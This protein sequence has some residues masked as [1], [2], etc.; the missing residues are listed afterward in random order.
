MLK[1]FSLS[2]CLLGIWYSVQAQEN[3]LEH[4]N[5]TFIRGGDTL[6]LSDIGGINTPIYNNIDLNN[7]GIEDLVIFDRSSN[8]ILPLLYIGE[9]Q[10]IA[11]KFAPEYTIGFPNNISEFLLSYDYNGDNIKDIIYNSTETYS[12]AIAKGNYI[13]NKIHFEIVTEEIMV[14]F[15]N[16]TYP[17]SGLRTDLPT[18]G[19][20]DNDGDMDILMFTNSSTYFDYIMWYKNMAIERGLSLDSLVFEEGSDCFAHMGETGIDNTF[21][22]S[23]DTSICPNNPYWRNPRHIGSTITAIDHNKD[24]VLDLV[25]GDIEYPHL[26]LVSLR[27]IG[28]T[29]IAYAQD[30]NYPSNDTIVH[31]LD[32]P[33]AYYVDINNDGKLDL[34]AANFYNNSGLLDSTSWLYLNHAPDANSAMDMR[35]ENKAFLYDQMLDLGKGAYPT[36]VDLNADGLM[37]LVIGNARKGYTI[38][39]EFGS[40]YAFMNVGTDTLPIFELIN[41]D[42]AQLS[43][44]QQSKLI[45]DFGDLNGDGAIDMV[46]GTEMGYIYI[47]LNQ[48]APDQMPIYT[49]AENTVLE[50]FHTDAG[51]LFGNSAPSLYDFDNDGDLDIVSGGNEG[52]LFYFENTGNANQYAFDTIPTNNRFGNVYVQHQDPYNVQIVPRVITSDT[53]TKM[54]LAY[55]SSDIL[56]VS[57]IDE[58]LLGSFDVNHSDLYSKFSKEEW[59]EQSLDLADLN[60]DSILDLVIG[61]QRGGVNFFFSRAEISDTTI[62]LTETILPLQKINI[63]PNPAKDHIFIDF[64]GK[65]DDNPLLFIYNL[66]GQLVQT[67]ALVGKESKQKIRLDNLNHGIYIISL[68]NA[69]NIYSTKLYLQP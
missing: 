46:V 26:N 42:F 35:L 14:P 24:G 17:I 58:N 10:S 28:N 16:Y 61:N 31:I 33:A 55:N 25:I 50:I 30:N 32:M 67:Y 3:P 29:P 65:M 2:L 68:Q 6:S 38:G 19:D 41:N 51:Y 44:L 5:I 37:D 45:T 52:N 1:I 15:S 69:Q 20:I 40:L 4:K 66:Q 34:L 48:A 9:N 8:A 27:M 59:A 64:E 63:Y 39:N 47:Y 23:L 22:L 11:Y 54:Y 60:N 49:I 56:E 13:D 36:F 12:F 62:A 43:N 57:N 21:D 7:D 53:G 18:V